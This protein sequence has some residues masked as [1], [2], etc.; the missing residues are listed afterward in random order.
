VTIAGRDT[1]LGPHGS[2]ESRSEYDRVVAEWLATRSRPASADGV[3]GTDLTI[4]EFVVA[5]TE[6]ADAYYVKD[7]RPTSEAGNVRLALR[8]LRR[9]Y[10]PTLARD[11]GP[12]KLKAVRQALIDSGLCRSEVNRRIRLIVR[13]F[14]WAVGN[15][16]VPAA[17]H[18]G[19]K[20]VDGLRKGRCGVRESRPI[21]PVP[22]AFVDAIRPYVSRQVWAMIEIQRHTGMRPGEAC[23]MRTADINTAGRIWEYT[24]ESHKTEHHDKRRTI[25]IGPRAQEIIKPWLRTTLEEYLFQ[26]REAVAERRAA[27]RAARKTKVQPS[28]R[29]RRKRDPARAIGDR[30]NARSYGHAIADA[31]ARAFPHPVLAELS[32]KDVDDARRAELKVWCAANR[33]ELKAWRKSHRWHPNQLRHAAGTRVRREMGLEASQVVLGHSRADVTQVYAERDADLARRAMERLG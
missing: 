8:P 27:M 23:A 15:E 19:L 25:Y 21:E 30:Y 33:A 9:L 7:G 10:G 1:Y 12:L 2:P 32:R 24:P 20:A 22:D 16:I 29:D 6:H 31:C 28:Q 3:R 14:K 18:H 13:A 17:V 4:T 5:Y 26:P 11:F